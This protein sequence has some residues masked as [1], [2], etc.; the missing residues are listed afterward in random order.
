LKKI[1]LVVKSFLRLDILNCHLIIVG[2]TPDVAV[3]PASQ[4]I[5]W[6][7][8]IGSGLPLKIG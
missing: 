1:E 3:L 6:Q 4:S 7:Q 8:A 5:I 2:D